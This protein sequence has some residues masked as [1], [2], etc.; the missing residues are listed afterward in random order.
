MGDNACGP[1]I[2]KVLFLLEA[3]D[4][5]GIEKVTLDIVNHLDS[6]K[7]SITVQT[8]RYGGH[9][10]SL[11]NDKIKVIP[12]FSKPYVRGIIRLI[13]YL[14]PKLLY[15]LFVHGD[16]DVEIAA[17][18]GGAAKVIS[19]SMNKMAK[20]MLGTYGCN[21]TRFRTKKNIAILIR[22]DKFTVNLMRLLF[23]S[24]ACQEVSSI[25]W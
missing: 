18:D 12:F 7:Y 23:V 15:R 8:F 6:E 17:S 21:C 1:Y 25:I 19:G 22:P 20:N 24:G 14:P 10:Q 5:G 16:Y 3:F 2:M 9:F 11:V 4:V 13:Q